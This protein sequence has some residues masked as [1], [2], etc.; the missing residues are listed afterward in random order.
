MVSNKEYNILSFTGTNILIWIA[1]LLIG[2]TFI[3][4]LPS[5]LITDSLFIKYSDTGEIGDS[6]GG[7]TGPI[8]GLIAAILTFWAFWVQYRANQQQRHDLAIERFENKYYEMIRLHKENVNEMKI[9]G[10]TS[11]KSINYNSTK[12]K[13]GTTIS[14]IERIVD[15]RKVF[16]SMV[17]ELLTCYSYCLHKNELKD[18]DKTEKLKFAYKIFFFGSFSSLTGEIHSKAV[19]KSIKN[20]LKN[21]RRKHKE[22]LGKKKTISL[23]NGKKSTLHIKYAPFTGHESRLGH[24]YRH[25]FSTVKYVVSKHQEGLF[26]YTQA[27]DYLKIL[28]AQ[29]SNDEHLL[30][31]YN[32]ITGFGS[33]WENSQ[34]EFFSTYRMLHNLPVDRVRYVEKPR[35]HFAKQMERIRKETNGKEEMFEWDEN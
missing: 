2:I 19:T 3:F 28:R 26:G 9:T 1:A 20:E 33:R 31:Y 15:G 13:L 22:T 4:C 5:F 34:N 35:Q 6:I 29:M 24:Y 16:V 7:I 8:V 10:Y 32:Y 21:F 12:E 25:L 14:Q 23:D 11:L 30:L 17:K 18:I 27:R